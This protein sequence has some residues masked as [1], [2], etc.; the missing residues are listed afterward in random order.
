MT[1]TRYI[2][3]GASGFVGARLQPFLDAPTTTL[4]MSAHDWHRRVEATDFAG[5]IVMHL[6]GRAH[7]RGAAQDF[8]RDNVEKT[9][10]LAEAAAR[11]GARGLVFLSS[12]KVNGERS[13]RPFTE[14]DAPAPEDAY[15]RSK[16]DA[17]ASLEGLAQRTGLRV[18]IVRSPLVYGPGAKG[19]LATLMRVADS[20]LPLP[21]AA[22]RNRRSFIALDDL[23]RVLVRC[24][25]ATHA[26][27]RTYLVA[28]RDAISTPALVASV[29]RAFGRPAHLYAMPL[30]LVGAFASMCGQR[31][32]FERLTT[33][34]EVDPSHAA[35]DLGWRAQVGADAAIDAMV[36]AYR[37]GRA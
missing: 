8:H 27:S 37:A 23:C 11:Q 15:G 19:H 18:T 20:P 34:L 36:A 35:E 4:A 22:I 14:A 1:A 31:G 28:H 17:E 29:R 6:A 7:T 12:V 5:A 16:R 30:S 3:T 33:S 21:F 2:V 32:A 9:R 24:A 13:D 26:G 10:A 25:Q